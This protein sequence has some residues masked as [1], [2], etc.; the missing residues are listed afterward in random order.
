M[1]LNEFLVNATDLNKD[2]VTVHSSSQ[3]YS[4]TRH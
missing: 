2:E 3:G 1:A 4:R